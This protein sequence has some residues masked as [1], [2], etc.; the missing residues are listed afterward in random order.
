DAERMGLDEMIPNAYQNLGSVLAHRGDLAR[1]RHAEEAAV[2]MFERLGYQ[3][4]GGLSRAYLAEV[5]LLARHLEAAYREASTSAALL[6]STPPLRA[7]AMAVLGRVLLASERA[8]EALGAAREAFA[9]LNEVGAEEGE[10]LIRLVHA[11]ALAASG[12][13]AEANVA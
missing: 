11:E 12:S 1:A 2:A 8:G 6:Q 13:Q 4:A 9:L 3:R 7:N 5:M 10:S